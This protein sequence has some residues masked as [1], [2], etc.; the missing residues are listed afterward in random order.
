MTQPDAIDIET[1]LLTLLHRY[2][3]YEYQKR[4]ESDI[5]NINPILERMGY[6]PIP[7]SAKRTTYEDKKD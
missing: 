7:K 5:D 1:I 4:L 3:D 6:K 2:S